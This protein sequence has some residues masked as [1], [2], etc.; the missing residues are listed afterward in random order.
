MKKKFDLF[1]V[2][3]QELSYFKSENNNQN[4]FVTEK[5]QLPIRREGDGEI[6]LKISY[7]RKKD[8]NAFGFLSDLFRIT[9]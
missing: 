3:R 7:H 9:T 2:F 6:T 4:E 1:I 5:N 8:G